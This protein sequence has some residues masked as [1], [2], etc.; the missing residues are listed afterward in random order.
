MVS[1]VQILCGENLQTS[2]HFFFFFD[3]KSVRQA[4]DPFLQM[5]K[6]DL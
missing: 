2:S 6:L 4:L 3:N 5:K 1:Q